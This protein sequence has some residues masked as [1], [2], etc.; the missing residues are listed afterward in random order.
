LTGALRYPN[1]PSARTPQPT[2][3]LSS[4]ARKVNDPIHTQHGEEVDVSR[5]VSGTG[6]FSLLTRSEG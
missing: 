6:W 3:A 1:G 5:R 4:G 2:A